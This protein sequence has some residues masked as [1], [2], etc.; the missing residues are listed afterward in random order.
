MRLGVA[1]SSAFLWLAFG[2]EDGVADF[3]AVGDREDSRLLA[4]PSVFKQHRPVRSERLLNCSIIKELAHVFH[5]NAARKPF[6]I[7]EPEHAERAGA[8]KE[9]RL[10]LLFIQ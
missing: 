8:D 1:I 6:F 2:L 5:R 7:L 4:L 3:Y 9:P 10:P